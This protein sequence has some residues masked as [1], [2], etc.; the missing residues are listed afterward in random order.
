MAK[1]PGWYGVWALGH[2]WLQ[3]LTL[4]SPYFSNFP[5]ETPRFAKTDAQGA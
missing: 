2:K 1:A 5:M 4:N 3:R